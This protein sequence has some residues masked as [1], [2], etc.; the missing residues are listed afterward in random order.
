MF[1]R[2]KLENKQV[3]VYMISLLMATV[4]G[5]LMPGYAESL[6]AFISII[7]ALLMYSMFS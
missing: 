6:G 4:F 2:K 5:F 3:W 7:I 1:T